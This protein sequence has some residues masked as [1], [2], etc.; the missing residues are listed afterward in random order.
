MDGDN[1]QTTKAT[2]AV[3]W[4]YKS[5]GGVAG[6]VDAAA[7]TQPAAAKGDFVEWSASEFV[8][9]DKGFG[10]YAVLVLG[11]ILVSAGL[12]LLTRD[13]F[14]V[15]VVLI[16]AAILGVAS[17]RKPRIINYRL[18]NAG[19]TAGKKFYPYG[20]Y[21]SFSMPEDGPFAAIVL[22]PMKRLSFPT[23]AYLAPDSQQK[24]VDILANHLPL[25]RDE[26]TLFDQV[27]NQLRF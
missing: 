22:V 1:K 17:A 14:S 16:M 2:E 15:I 6:S 9:H 10:W 23:G 19:L 18:D 8:A 13:K 4:Q 26:L 12:Y 3:G 25:E 24:A 11:T 5:A 20:E 27:V 7:E 21:K